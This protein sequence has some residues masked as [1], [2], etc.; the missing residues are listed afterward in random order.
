MS[1]HAHKLAARPNADP[2]ALARCAAPENPSEAMLGQA[3]ACLAIQA[4]Q[5]AGSVVVL[6]ALTGLSGYRPE[7]VG[8][9]CA[10]WL[11]AAPQLLMVAVAM[12]GLL[13][14]QRSWARDRRDFVLL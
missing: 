13:N 9:T 1:S 7:W 4:M 12:G 3:S 6:A 5:L 10:A 8:V 2:A 11:G 14:L